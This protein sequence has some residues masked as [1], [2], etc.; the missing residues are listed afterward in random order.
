MVS[1]LSGNLF[2]TINLPYYFSTNCFSNLDEI[3]HN[4]GVFKISLGFPLIIGRGEHQKDIHRSMRIR[5]HSYS[6]SRYKKH[7]SR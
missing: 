2:N 5:L 1:F 7:F 4:P 3:I 6:D